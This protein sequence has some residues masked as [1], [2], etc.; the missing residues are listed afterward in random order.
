MDAKVIAMKAIRYVL[1]LVVLGLAAGCGQISDPDGIRVAKMDGEYITRGDLKQV[2]YN[3]DDVERPK[4]IIRGDYLRVLNK[5][6]DGKITIALGDQLEKEKKIS[7][8]REV[9]REEF[10]KQCGDDEEQYRNIWTMEPPASG[11]ITP[12]MKLYDL[13][14][15]RMKAMKDIVE[16]KTDHIVQRMLGER[17]VE[18]LAA[19]D[20]Q[21]G[22]ITLDQEA[23]EREYRIRKDTLKKFEWMRFQAIRYTAAQSDALQQA[24]RISERLNAGES[25][26]TLVTEVQTLQSSAVAL[27]GATATIIESE[28]ENNPGLAKFRGFWSQ[29]SGAKPGSIIGPIY[30]PEYQQMSQDSQGRAKVVNMPDAWLVLKV[31]EIRPEAE[32]TIDEAKGTLAPPILVEEEMKRLREQHGVEIYEDQLPDPGQGA[33]GR[34]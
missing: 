21:A 24:A 15:Q 27:P 30:L 3:M 16:Q 23:L 8:P 26:E 19:Q 9:A 12:L 6:I 17:A 20:F 10:F 1:C 33:M 31:I 28:I 18:Y 22:T 14:P 5:Y 11:E 13:T 32:M 2:I 25:F 7:V 34:G 4:I 29:A